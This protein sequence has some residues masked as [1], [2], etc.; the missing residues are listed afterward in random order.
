LSE[1]RKKG[2]DV[3]TLGKKKRVNSSE[4]EMKISGT[5][6]KSGTKNKKQKVNLEKEGRKGQKVISHFIFH[7]LLTIFSYLNLLILFAS[8]YKL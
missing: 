5:G 7:S 2:K 4:D 3:K 8:F 6:G 1:G